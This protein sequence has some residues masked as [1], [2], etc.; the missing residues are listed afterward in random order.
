MATP[1]PCQRD[2]TLPCPGASVLARQGATTMKITE[3]LFELLLP[4]A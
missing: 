2:N 1:W 3:S 4:G